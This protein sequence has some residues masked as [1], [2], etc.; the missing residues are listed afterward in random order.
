MTKRLRGALSRM[1]QEPVLGSSEVFRQ[2]G[3]PEVCNRL[4]RCLSWAEDGTVQMI[5]RLGADARNTETGKR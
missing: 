4:P 5:V 2:Q 3:T 1:P